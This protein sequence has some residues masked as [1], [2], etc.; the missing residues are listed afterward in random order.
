MKNSSLYQELLVQLVSGLKTL[1]DKPEE[2]PETTLCALWHAAA[3]A[4]KSAVLAAVTDLPSLD[5]TAEKTLRDLIKQRLNGAPLA[6]ITHRQRFVDMEM[7]AGPE[8]LVP[9]KETELLART[10]IDLA[11]QI[12]AQQGKATMIDVCTGSGNVALAVAQHVRGV[13]VFAADISEDAVALAR[14]NMQHLRLD[15]RVQFAAG[16]LLAPFDN[17]EFHARVDLLSG[18]PPYITSAKVKE[19]PNEIS[20]HEP[21]LAFDGGAFGVAI[22]MRL[23]KEA[24]RF[25]RP[26]G[27]FVSEIGLGQGPVLGKLLNKNPAFKEVRMIEDASGA[28]RVVMARC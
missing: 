27:W 6:H 1:P 14:R 13:Q 17:P 23:V 4:P 8:A 26:G 12:V 20:A 10:A 28:V 21:T 25:L 9:R 16:D 11:S 2:T 3:G 22:I 5:K 18:N 7:L 15:G 24:P 19:M